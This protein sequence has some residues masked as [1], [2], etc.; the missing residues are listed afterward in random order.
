V[1][2]I[3]KAGEWI[4]DPITIIDP[5]SIAIKG[6]TMLATGGVMADAVIFS[7]VSYL[8]LALVGAIVS[9]FGVAHEVFGTGHTKY[10][11]GET[12]AE[13][14]KGIALGV[15]A[16]PFW[17]IMFTTVGDGLMMEHFKASPD[18]GTFESLS[19]IIAFGMSWFT[20]PIFDFIAKTIPSVVNS[21]VSKLL[22]KKGD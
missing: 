15:L 19:L 18:A 22:L 7:D 14:L 8:Y 13:L 5:T 16:I 12:V 20:V 10:S 2:K 9:M 21:Y 3:N 4:M 17:Y 6:G 11:L 1:S